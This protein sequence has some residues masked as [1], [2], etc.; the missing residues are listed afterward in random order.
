MNSSV[1]PEAVRRIETLRDAVLDF[2]RVGQRVVLI[3]AQ[4]SP[5]IVHAI[6]EAIDDVRLDHMLP[7]R[8]A[9]VVDALENGQAKIQREFLG[10]AEKPCPRYA[11]FCSCPP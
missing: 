4:E 7:F 2:V 10:V 1:S 3:E 8:I 9:V 5:E 6:H 11:P